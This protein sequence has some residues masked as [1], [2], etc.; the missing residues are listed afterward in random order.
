MA[1][2]WPSNKLG[3]EGYVADT[4]ELVLTKKPS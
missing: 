2:T 3:L 1:E 4:K